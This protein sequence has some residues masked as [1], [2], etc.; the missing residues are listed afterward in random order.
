MRIRTDRTDSLRHY[1][2]TDKMQCRSLRANVETYM[3]KPSTFNSNSSN[4]KG[5][6]RST[7]SQAQTQDSMSAQKSPAKSA[8]VT[9]P[10]AKS[11]TNT[12]PSTTVS[13]SYTS[14]SG[15]GN[16]SGKPSGKSAG[17]SVDKKHC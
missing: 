1:N 14:Q 17:Q 8:Q 2:Q 11:S 16:P 3:E 10:A 15:S 4:A 9:K 5:G 7:D 13:G 6:T 12:K